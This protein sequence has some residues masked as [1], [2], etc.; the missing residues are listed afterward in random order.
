[1]STQLFYNGRIIT[2]DKDTPDAECMLVENEKIAYLGD[3]AGVPSDLQ[4]ERVDLAGKLVMPSFIDAHLHL[5]MTMDV[6]LGLDLTECE[7]IGDYQDK[8]RKY[9]EENPGADVIKGF[10]WHDRSFGDN[11]PDKKILDEI[12]PDIPVALAADSLHSLWVNSR[13]LEL[14]D[15]T[16]ETEDLKSGS[17]GRYES[18]E[19]SGVIK[20]DCMTFINQAI[21]DYTIEQYKEVFTEHIAHLNSL[22]FTGFYDAKLEV[23]SNAIEALKELSLENRL[24]GY[25]QC[26]YF[27]YPFMDVEEQIKSFEEARNRD[28]VSDGFSVNSVKVMLDGV[29]ESKTGYLKEPYLEDGKAGDYRGIAEW[30]QDDLNKAVLLSMERGF[31]VEAHC[32]GDAALEQAITAFEYAKSKGAK[33]NRNKI[34]HIEL[35]SDGDLE[36]M[37]A[38]EIVPCLS[39]YWAQMDD[40]YMAMID[41]VGKER[42]DR[43]W[44]INSLIKAGLIC[45]TGSDYPITE[46]PNPFVGIEIGMTRKIPENYH[47]WAVMKP[48]EE[49]KQLGPDEEKAS[50]PEM[51]KMYTIGS[52]YSMHIDDVTG[53]LRQGKNADFIIVDKDISAVPVK[54]ISSIKVM[55]TYFKGREVYHNAD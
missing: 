22:G 9:A 38:L 44:P 48:F 49:Y 51:I 12:I 15:I 14:A 30:E 41:F 40:L 37:K 13:A 35:I 19:P 21:P 6:S 3:M 52:A 31:Q 25:M 8:L 2:M 28:N 46:V 16:E 1:M 36:R 20:E 29:I 4:Y 47:P 54:D 45:A 53:S 27:M 11:G 17:I 26:V 10:G 5:G 42:A 33:A 55:A 34:A 7:T 18:G 39:P 24:N 23:N 50:L 43:I 32:I